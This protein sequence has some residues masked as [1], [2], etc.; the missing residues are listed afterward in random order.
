MT[1]KEYYK[2]LEIDKTTTQEQIKNAYY[3]LSLKYH[4]DKNPNGEAK[5]KEISEAYEVLSD[6]EKRK[7]Y[8]AGGDG[9]SFDEEQYERDKAAT[10]EEIK[11]NKEEQARLR[12][13]RIFYIEAEFRLYQVFPSDLDPSL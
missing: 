5:F 11:K 2:I 12:E 4:P 6:P 9:S 10:A 13:G 7:N 3:K 8:D 1:R